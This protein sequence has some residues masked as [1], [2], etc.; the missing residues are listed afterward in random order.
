MANVCLKSQ[1]SAKENALPIN[2][3]RE[4]EESSVYRGRGTQMGFCKVLFSATA[5]RTTFCEGK[6]RKSGFQRSQLESEP[7]WTVFILK[8]ALLD[9]GLQQN[10]FSSA[11]GKLHICSLVS[12]LHSNLPLAR[13]SLW[14]RGISAV[15]PNTRCQRQLCCDSIDFHRVWVIRKHLDIVANWHSA[16]QTQKETDFLPGST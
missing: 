6:P 14:L 9:N 16:V 15:F 7:K 2:A 8:S 13:L 11:K 12:S 4:K 5:S 3:W 1:V 10:N